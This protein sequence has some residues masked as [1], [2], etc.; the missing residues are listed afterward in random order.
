MPVVHDRA[1]LFARFPFGESSL[2]V[3]GL[4]AAHGRVHWIAK[5]VY[6]PTSRYFAVLDLFDTLELEWDANPR[7][8]LAGLRAGR[9][10]VRRPGLCNDLA[11]YHAGLT[12]L[13]LIG[14]VAHPSQPE[15][16]LFELCERA[17]D[18]LDTPR[19][20]PD[21]TLALFEL[22]LLRTL[23]LAPALERCAACGGEAPPVTAATVESSGP[24]V[25]FSAGAGGRLCRRC[26]EEAR[27]HG[28]RVGTL[29]V[30]VLTDAGELVRD[31][32]EGSSTL[33]EARIDRIRDFV[34]RFVDY[35]L[36]RQPRTHRAFLSA[37][38]RN[39][40][41]LAHEPL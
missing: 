1:L 35:H 36:E 22:C 19:R 28:R 21:L 9:I 11:A 30:R 10:A 16:A 12:V 20:S 38:N 37:P 2:V 17:L 23:G 18:A 40:A 6:R 34:G 15:P 5:G 8:E 7:R 31:G 25:A 14:L 33:P 27:S 29:P 26:A 4:S 13:E 24:R 39:A 41:N 32:V 3:H